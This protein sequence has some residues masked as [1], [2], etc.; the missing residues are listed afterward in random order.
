[1]PNVVKY[2]TSTESLSLRKGNFYLGIGDVGKGPTSSTGFYNGINPP[3]GGY[4]IYL[5][6]ASGGPSIY[7]ASND[8][9]LISLTNQIAG[10]SYT[11]V[12]QCFVY[13]AGQS[14]KI[15]VNENY[16]SIIT[17]GLTISLDG[18]FV[19]SYPKS[20]TTWYDNS[21]SANNG[22]LTN[23]PTF[24]S[25]SNS[26]VFDGSDDLV[27]V[28]N[29]ASIEFTSGS[30]EFWIYNQSTGAGQYE[31]LCKHSQF[32]S[33]NGWGIF[34]QSNNVYFYLKGAA[35]EFRQIATSITANRWTHF[36][37][38]FQTTEPALTIYKN[39]VSV[40]NGGSATTIATN[41]YEFRIGSSND[42]WWS[43][44][45][46][47]MSTVRY[48]NYILSNS[49]ILQNYYQ[50]PVTTGNVELYLDAGNLVSYLSGDTTTYSLTGSLGG[51]LL[52]GTG[53]DT[54]NGGSYVFDGTDDG[55]SS[56]ANL[57]GMSTFTIEFF[58]KFEN[59]PNFASHQILYTVGDNVGLE[60]EVSSKQ[61]YMWN[62][63]VNRANTTFN[64]NTWYHV[65]WTSQSGSTIVYVNGVLDNSFGTFRGIGNGF[66]N[67][68]YFG[69]GRRMKGNLGLMR[70][71][72][73]VLTAAEVAQNFNAQRDRFGI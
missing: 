5:N 35:G 55:I 21:V 3:S 25:V 34:V 71:Y 49:Q 60:Y 48:Y 62:G 44:W 16:P 22:T 17:S 10:T 51:T 26:I 11:G 73:K 15:V 39:G 38:Y 42:G 69:A 54:K 72:S 53:F 57:P 19:S 64:I 29:S 43:K 31:F 1:M 50:G 7:T 40:S 8:A 52:N 32:G 37:C 59:Q 28:S 6:K 9:G 70:I 67:I 18:N 12:Q 20:G 47:K 33:S 63:S 61:I 56:T 30:V 36:I 23:G 46:G 45:A 65:T 58:I 24:D 14:D 66:W 4:T 68:G 13:F 2:N 41:N 27:S